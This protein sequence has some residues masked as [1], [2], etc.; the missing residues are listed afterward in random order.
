MEV[1]FRRRSTD[2]IFEEQNLPRNVKKSCDP[3]LTIRD[4]L[5]TQQLQTALPLKTAAHKEFTLKVV[6]TRP[7]FSSCPLHQ[8][9]TQ[10]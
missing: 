3:E 7:I 9:L 6:K 5:T 2:A 4:Y 8:Y 1:E 10:Q